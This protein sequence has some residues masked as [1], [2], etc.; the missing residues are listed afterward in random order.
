MSN[1]FLQGMVLAS[2]FTRYYFYATSMNIIGIIENPLLSKKVQIINFITDWRVFVPGLFLA[3]YIV[4][5]IAASHIRNPDS[6]AYVH[7]GPYAFVGIYKKKLYELIPMEES[8]RLHQLQRTK[9][10]P[11]V[12]E[13]DRLA[14]LSGLEPDN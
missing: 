9:A 4:G 14:P 11:E 8:V 10:K 3:G 5:I 6:V 7:Q 12:Q 1:S 2:Y 13:T